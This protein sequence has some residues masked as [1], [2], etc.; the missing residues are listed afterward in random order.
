[1]AIS[2]GSL[3]K[4]DDMVNGFIVNVW[5]P[6]TAN[7]Y[8]SGNVPTESGYNMIQPERL[9][10][11]T[12]TK[13]K[14]DNKLRTIG[15]TGKQM[16]STKLYNVTV[17][18]TKL[19]TKVGTWSYTRTYNT[20]GT[21]TVQH[22]ASGK[23]MFS[24]AYIKSLGASPNRDLIKAHDIVS[25]NKLNSFYASLLNAWQQTSRHSNVVRNDLCHTQ[26]HSNC[27]DNC[28]SNS[29]YK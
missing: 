14:I 8:H 28:H 23:A 16:N 20:D 17:E 12:N 26:C 10:N 24:D 4:V 3:P 2:T 21:L 13:N 19:L 1:M 7:A 9:G 18:C 22:T 25:A 15:S 29:C 11:L 6:I 5:N 27:H